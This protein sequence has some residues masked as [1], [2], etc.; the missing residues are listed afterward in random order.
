ML[1]II[2]DIMYLTLVERETKH[3]TRNLVN[4]EFS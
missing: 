2:G 4:K 3:K 1:K